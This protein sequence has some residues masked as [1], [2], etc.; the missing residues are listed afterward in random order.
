[1]VP[2]YPQATARKERDIYRC[3]VR[4]I[5][6]LPFSDFFF[7]IKVSAAIL[8]FVSFSLFDPRDIDSDKPNLVPRS[9]VDEAEG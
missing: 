8:N 6:T 2:Q 5:P 9:L 4:W 3:H 1:M 7:V